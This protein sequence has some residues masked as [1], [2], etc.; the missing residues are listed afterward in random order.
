MTKTTESASELRRALSVVLPIMHGLSLKDTAA[1]I[2]RSEAWVA[3]AR[4]DFIEVKTGQ[5]DGQPRGGRRNQLIPA[6]EEDAFMDSVCQQYIIL[7]TKRRYRVRHSVFTEEQVKM[8]FVEFTQD[9]VERR[10]QRKTTRTTVYNLLS[11]VG[12]RRF[13][14]YEPDMW[15]YACDAQIP[16][17]QCSEPD[18]V[19]A[20][21]KKYRPPRSKR[22][23]A[24]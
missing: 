22:H 13:I 10:I 15:D 4:R 19:E 5:S 24:T 17:F 23:N 2:G 7:H 1:L 3:K 6:N 8:S 16:G 9:A 12:K 14:N 21:I 18:I 11:R 20:L